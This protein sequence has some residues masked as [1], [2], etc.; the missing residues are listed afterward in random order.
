MQDVVD[1]I[2]RGELFTALLAAQYLTI[3]IVTMIFVPCTTHFLQPLF[4]FLVG[5][6]EFVVG[7]ENICNIHRHWFRIVAGM[8]HFEIISVGS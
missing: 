8:H 3:D 7:M 1:D 5:R 6:G 2:S 4:G